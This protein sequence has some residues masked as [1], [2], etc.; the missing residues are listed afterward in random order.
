MSLPLATRLLFWLL[1]V[2]LLLLAVVGLALAV[3]DWWSSICLVGGCVRGANGEWWIRG[4][5]ITSILA[6]SLRV[7]PFSRTKLKLVPLR[8]F[9]LAG[10]LEK[11]TEWDSNAT[12]RWNE[13]RSHDLAQLL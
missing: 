12:H 2:V 5:P 7:L 8:A 6:I 9:L 11:I 13:Q 3:G 10:E 4:G 1:V